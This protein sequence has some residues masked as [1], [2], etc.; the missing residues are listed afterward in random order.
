MF[1]KRDGPFSGFS[2][3]KEALDKNI[4]EL[5]GSKVSGALGSS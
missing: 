2:R 4:A 1:G 5:N 3:C